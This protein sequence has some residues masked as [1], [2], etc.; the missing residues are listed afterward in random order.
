MSPVRTVREE[1]F[2]DWLNGQQEPTYSSVDLKQVW[3]E[4]WESA[5][6]AVLAESTIEE[7]ARDAQVAW[8]ASPAGQRRRAPAQTEEWRALDGASREAWHRVAERA[9][10]GAVHRVRERPESTAG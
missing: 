3:D 2:T 9:I 1:R 10:G 7:A 4:A 6:Q 5:L 8:L